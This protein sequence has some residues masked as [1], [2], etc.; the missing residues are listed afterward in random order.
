MRLD[1]PTVQYCGSSSE[2]LKLNALL[3]HRTQ[4]VAALTG[5]RVVFLTE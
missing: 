2:M 4:I 3:K 1:I 5:N